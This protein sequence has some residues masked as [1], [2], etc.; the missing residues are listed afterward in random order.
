[1]M[2]DSINMVSEK[3]IFLSILFL[4]FRIL[5]SM[6]TNEN[7]Q[8]TKNIWVM[9]VYSRNISVKVLSNYSRTLMA[10]TL[11]ALL[12]RLFRTRS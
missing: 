5:V 12:P 6:E 2:N 3:I 4:F 1:M 7:E 9:L 11:M 10:R 8:W